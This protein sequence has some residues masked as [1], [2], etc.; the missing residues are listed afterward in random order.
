MYITNDV[1]TIQPRFQETGWVEAYVF[2]LDEVCKKSV[3]SDGRHN[4]PTR[5]QKTLD[6]DTQI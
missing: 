4:K 6:N 2:K 5:A 3:R 1:K